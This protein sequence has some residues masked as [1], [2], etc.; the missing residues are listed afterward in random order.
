MLIAE[1]VAD[2]RSWSMGSSSVEAESGFDV[3]ETIFV[4]VGRNVEESKTALLWA[5]R[6]F[7]GMKICLLHVHQPASNVVV[8][9]KDRLL[10]ANKAKKVAAEG[11][12]ELE[13]RKV[14]D[15]LTQYFLILGQEGVKPYEVWIEAMSIEEGIVE[16]VDRYYVK[17]LVMGAAADKHYSKKLAEIKSKKAAFVWQHAA[18]SCHI[19]FLCNGRLIY[20]REG[21]DDI[22]ESEIDDL[23]LLLTY[24]DSVSEKPEDLQSGFAA[25]DVSPDAVDNADGFEALLTKF[26]NDSSLDAR[27]SIE[28]AMP[29]LEHKAVEV[30]EQTDASSTSSLEG[31]AVDASDLSKK[32]FEEVV[33]RWKE[34]EN[35]IEAKC[36]AKA[37]ES[38]CIKEI[39]LR[40]EMEEVLAR[41]RD[42]VERMGNQH[43]EL[44]QE[45]KQVKE[46][47]AVLEKQIGDANR[48]VQELEEKIVAAVELLI[49]FRRQRDDAKVECENA[50]RE[51]KRLQEL[52]KLGAT[53]FH[54]SEILEFSF[55]EIIEATSEFDPA[56]KIQEGRY[57][58]IYKG[59]LRHLLVTIKMLPS[60]GSQLEFQNGVKI[61]SKVRHPNLVTM[62]GICP[63]ARSLVLEYAKNGSLEDRL[64]CKGK[65][66]PLTWQTRLRIASE[67][68]SALIFIHSNKPCVIHGNLKPS[69]VL[70]DS[71]LV[72]KL[73]DFGMSHLIPQGK[74]GNLTPESDVDSFGIILLLL[75]TARPVSGILKDVKCALEN[76]KLEAVLDHSAGKWPDELAKLLANMALKC[77]NGD[78]LI[79][80]DLLSEIYPVLD[81]MLVLPSS[82]DSQPPSSCLDAKEPRRVPSHFVCPIFQEVMKDP[83]IAADGF[84]YEGDAIK[85]W[86]K[87]G[88]N[89]SPMTNLKMEHCD[90][91]PN[92]ALYQA[93]QEWRE[94]QW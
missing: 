71:N 89:T 64:A 73:Y 74:T 30:K 79:R 92:H 84:T 50:V 36:K 33:K 66:R 15:I 61:L 69:K 24:S 12:E 46:Q 14:A 63:E 93:I 67:I 6:N 28:T 90:L 53:S 68:C 51:V 39:S 85:G 75:L 38:L 34:E 19:W 88:H 29:L 17:W 32:A 10:A 35:A 55:E 49:S 47:K 83:Q 65:S 48:V 21:R 18:M 70:L 5:V 25:F 45:L 41:E 87:S 3:E 54:G 40:K 31:S 7:S 13:R 59:L 37:L 2:S 22:C 62:I 44:Y 42:S 4:A 78:R 56:R 52:G 16:I 76:N 8:P 11:F 81:Q 1:L 80:A 86:L 94:Q 27:E 82:T 60:Y 77:C 43:D 57:G 26:D 20:T 9:F 91:L 72:C 23:P 58:T